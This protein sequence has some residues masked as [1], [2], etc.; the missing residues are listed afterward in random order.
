VR[1]NAG[2]LALMAPPDA[3]HTAFGVVSS[4][5]GEANKCRLRCSLAGR[6]PPLGA[7]SAAL[8]GSS[9]LL[10][11]PV[12]RFAAVVVSR[13]WFR[14][15]AGIGSPAHM[16]SGPEM[17]CPSGGG[18]GTLV[19]GTVSIVVGVGHIKKRRATRSHWL[20]TSWRLKPVDG[21]LSEQTRREPEVCDSVLAML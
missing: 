21:L 13:G 17:G 6:A 3:G 16:G 14:G 20:H 9:Q 12:A 4:L 15:S 10:W 2:S 18:K 8:L 19:L 11:L 1:E 5:P 7:D